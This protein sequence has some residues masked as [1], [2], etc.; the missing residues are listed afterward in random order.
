MLTVLMQ[1]LFV[2]VNVAMLQHLMCRDQLS[3]N[4]AGVVFCIYSCVAKCVWFDVQLRSVYPEEKIAPVCGGLG[5]PEI[6][7][8][9]LSISNI[10]NLL[11]Q[12]LLG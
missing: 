6:Q 4:T 2:G 5:R 7:L 9:S 12:A 8:F 11:S 10:L 3:V 1:G